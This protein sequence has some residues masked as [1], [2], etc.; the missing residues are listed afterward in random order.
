MLEGRLLQWKVGGGD[1]H[2]PDETYQVCLPLALAQTF[3]SDITHT[4]LYLTTFGLEKT[5]KCRRSPTF[6]Q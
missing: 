4:H 2:T 1:T 5:A 3:R 6:G